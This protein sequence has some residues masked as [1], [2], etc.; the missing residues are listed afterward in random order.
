[1]QDCC[2]GCGIHLCSDNGEQ[3]SGS[4]GRPAAAPKSPDESGAVAGQLY[5]VG[6]VMEDP[7]GS[8]CGGSRK[9]SDSLCDKP[10]T[11]HHFPGSG[12]KYRKRE[13]SLPDSSTVRREPSCFR[14][15]FPGSRPTGRAPPVRPESAGVRDPLPRGHLPTPPDPVTY[16]STARKF[17]LLPAGS[18]E[19][20][21]RR[22]RLR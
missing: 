3:E 19:F 16:C 20:L 1:M 4:G 8:P 6:G 21:S 10:G 2:A 9:I 17:L 22:F 13:G 7:P 14:R 11:R 12:Q 15:F 18:R 5:C